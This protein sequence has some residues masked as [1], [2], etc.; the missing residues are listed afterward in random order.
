[1]EPTLNT[2]YISAA[3]STG[4]VSTPRGIVHCVVRP[5][6]NVI[7]S[8]GRI[9]ACDPLVFPEAEP[10]TVIVGAGAYPV[11]LALAQVSDTDQRVAFAKLQFAEETA[12]TWQMALTPGQDPTKLRPNEIFG[13]AVDAGTGCFMDR[14]ASR[15]L[16]ARMSENREYYQAIVDAMEKTYVN[17]WSW[18][19]VRPSEHRDENCVVFS[20]GWGDG[21]YPS[22]F[23]YSDGGEL[24]CLVTDFDVLWREDVVSEEGPPKRKPWWKFW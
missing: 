6:G 19:D 10:F 18:A 4:E 7:L 22:Y 9:V 17:T 23:G 11:S 13:Y 16:E 21:V 12:A 24:V 3:F 14:E 5:I 2:E 1:M 15:L 8:T 20:S